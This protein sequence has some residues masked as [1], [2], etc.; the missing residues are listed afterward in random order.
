[1]VFTIYNLI[2]KQLRGRVMIRAHVWAEIHQTLLLQFSLLSEFF[3]EE[4]PVKSKT[5]I[6]RDF[7][8]SVVFIDKCQSM[9]KV[10]EFGES[11][12]CNLGCQLF[13]FFFLPVVQKLKS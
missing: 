9:T 2:G 3:N 11:Q 4:T 12:S 1:L 13:S 7:V 8:F 6:I 10:S 5:R